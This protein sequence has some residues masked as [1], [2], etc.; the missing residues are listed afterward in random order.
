MF[1]MLGVVAN[2]NSERVEAVIYMI[3]QNWC[4]QWKRFMP[5]VS[6]A[7]YFNFSKWVLSH[8]LADLEKLLFSDEFGASLHQ[9]AIFSLY[10]HC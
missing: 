8:M 4:E 3:F 1:I 10:E 5:H 9:T 7:A 2:G 6:Q